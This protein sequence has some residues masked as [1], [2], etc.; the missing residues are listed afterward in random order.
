M[1]KYFLSFISIC[2]LSF[3]AYATDAVKISGKVTDYNGCPVDSCT[4]LIYNPDFTEAYETLSNSQ[5]F[6]SLDSIPKGRYAA[7]AAMRVNEYPRM[8][9]VAPEDMKLEFWA[10]NVIADHDITLNIRYDKMELYGTK[11]F[12]EYGGRQEMLIYTR[13]MSVTKVIS[14]QNFVDKGEAEKNSIVTVEPQYMNF[15][16]YADGKPLEIFSVQPLNMLNKGNSVGNDICYLL[17]VELPQDI[18]EHKAPY[19]IRVVGHNSQYNEH[20]ESVYYFEPP[21]YNWKK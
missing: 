2:V 19:E 17:Q 7:I 21:K 5:G 20:G 4:V 6:Y 8:L 3:A 16:V 13:P 1:L 9:A 11:A 10:W 12:I 15:E 18:Y 14:Y